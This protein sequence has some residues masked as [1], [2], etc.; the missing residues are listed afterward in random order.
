MIPERFGI[1]LHGYATTDSGTFKA[2]LHE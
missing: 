2:I 1:R